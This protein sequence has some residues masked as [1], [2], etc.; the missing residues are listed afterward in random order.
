MIGNPVDLAASI[1]A[2]LVPNRDFDLT[3]DT[4]PRLS[5][6]ILS[7]ILDKTLRRLVTRAVP[8]NQHTSPRERT[9]RKRNR[10]GWRRGGSGAQSFVDIVDKVRCRALPPPR[11]GFAGPCFSLLHSIG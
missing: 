3:E 6:M 7:L 10:Y 8:P 2:G 1:D 9:G 5:A 4:T 11:N